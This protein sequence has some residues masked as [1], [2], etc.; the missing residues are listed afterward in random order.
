MRLYIRSVTTADQHSYHALCCYTLQHG[1]AT[2]IH[3]HV[4]DAYTA[5][6]ADDTPSQSPW[7]SPSS[8]CTCT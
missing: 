7:S 3:Q 5:Q 4:V 6:H 1:D 2:F 8:A